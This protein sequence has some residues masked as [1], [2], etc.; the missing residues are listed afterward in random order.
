MWR[1][2]A[3]ACRHE[4]WTSVWFWNAT[5]YSDSDSLDP[6]DVYAMHIATREWNCKSQM[7]YLLAEIEGDRD[8][9]EAFQNLAPVPSQTIQCLL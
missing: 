8:M 3:V 6:T 7:G 2:Y 9:E 4:M 5:G 1:S